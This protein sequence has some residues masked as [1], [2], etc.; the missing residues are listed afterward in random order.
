VLDT[1]AA[2]YAA[3]ARFDEAVLTVRR[4]AARARAEGNEALASDMAARERLYQSGRA[5]SEPVP[6]HAALDDGRGSAR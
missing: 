4:A 5:L 6:T 1:L 2:A 3:A